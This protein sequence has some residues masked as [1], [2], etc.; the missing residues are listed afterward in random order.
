MVSEVLIYVPSIANFRRS[1]LAERIDAAR[2]AALV[3][4]ASPDRMVPRELE[5]RLLDKVGAQMVVQEEG[6][7][8]RLLALSD[9]P[10]TI[11]ATFDLRELDVVGEIRWAFATLASPPGRMIR[12]VGSHGAQP[13]DFIEIV[14]DET[15]LRQAMFTYST[16][17]LTLSIIISVITAALVYLSLNWLL[18]RPMRRLTEA[19]LAFRAD[20]EDG[21]RIITPSGRSDE[22]GVAEREMA[23]MQ[24]ELASMLSQK[25]RLAALGLAVSKINHDLRNILASA[26]LVVDRVGTVD[27][28][29]AQRLAPKLVRTL[30]RAV[31]FC[32]DTLKYG[33]ARE[34][35]P[36]RQR[37]RLAPIVDE[38]AE[39]LEPNMGGDIV[40]VTAIDRRLEIDADTD[41]LFRVLM[42]LGRNAIEAMQAGAGGSEP[43]LRIAARREGSVTVIEV[44]DTGPGIP[45]RVR[46]RLFEPFQTSRRTGGTGLGLAIAAE[47]VTAHHGSIRLAEG[48]LGATFLI[49]IA[50]R[51]VELHARPKPSERATGSA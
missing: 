8:R 3:L 9:M 40:L 34:T 28:P 46:E 6:G 15:P 33:S 30:D 20:P 26:Q 10:P 22:I 37:V 25:N 21:D 16:N 36:Q 24:R 29:L 14:M 27:D 35:P 12:V 5:L 18:V 44:S 7:A 43:T 42:N 23:G 1:F 45:A 38:V 49:E 50:D 51:I 17:I 39:T 19:M 11:D 31:A 2:L 4:E 32:S 48:T 47:I 13:G 41:Q